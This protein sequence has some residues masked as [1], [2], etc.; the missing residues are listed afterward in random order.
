VVCNLL[1]RR[2]FSMLAARLTPHEAW[3]RLIK[4]LVAS[5]LLPLS[6]NS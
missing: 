1:F 6:G 3:P 4:A 5:R 2:C